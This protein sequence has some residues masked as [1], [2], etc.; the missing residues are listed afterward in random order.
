MSGG[1]LERPTLAGR[2]VAGADSHLH[3]GLGQ[4]EAHRL[5]PDAR[6]RAAQIP[7]HVDRERLER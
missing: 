7:L 5:L 6:Q 1:R 4:P 3:L 2:G